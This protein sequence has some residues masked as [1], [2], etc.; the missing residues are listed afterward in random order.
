MVSIKLPR[1]FHERDVIIQGLK[2]DC[3]AAA[4][5]LQTVV[6]EIQVILFKLFFFPSKKRKRKFYY[7]LLTINNN[8]SNSLKNLSVR[9]EQNKRKNKPGVKTQRRFTM[10]HFSLHF[11]KL[12]LIHLQIRFGEIQKIINF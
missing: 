4:E 1:G 2:E 6:K 9:M 11:L 3:E 10:M 8:S 7:F 5:Y 12:L